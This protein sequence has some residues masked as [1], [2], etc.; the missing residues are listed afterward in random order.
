MNL[1]NIIGKCFNYF[2]Y[3]D[4]EKERHFDLISNQFSLLYS[5]I[6]KSDLPPLLSFDFALS[7]L[8]ILRE[9][10]KLFS[11]PSSLDLLNQITDLELYLTENNKIEQSFLLSH[12]LSEIF[13]SIKA[14]DALKVFAEYS[15]HI[16][17]SNLHIG[18][19]TFNNMKKSTF[20]LYKLN[21]SS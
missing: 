10:L 19:R 5:E 2:R 18:I 11:T 16:E 1:K 6:M 21:Q 20:I 9:K 13:L 8:Q 14:C 7:N 17:P 3:F 15:S 4:A 12:L